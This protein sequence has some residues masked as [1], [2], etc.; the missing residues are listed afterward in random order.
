MSIF[1]ELNDDQWKMFI[2]TRNGNFLRNQT[3]YSTWTHQIIDPL[4]YFSAHQLDNRRN[5]TG[6]EQQNYSKYWIILILNVYLRLR[7]AFYRTNVNSDDDTK[8]RIKLN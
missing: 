6:Q 5:S 4:N 8:N 7:I 3:R 2:I 1:N